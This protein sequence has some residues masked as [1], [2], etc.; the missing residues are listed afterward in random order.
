MSEQ[1][2]LNK[3]IFIE[4][5]KWVEIQAQHIC[6]VNLK[7][8]NGFSGI[9]LRQFK[10]T[11]QGKLANHNATAQQQ[12]NEKP[13]HKKKLRKTNQIEPFRSAESQ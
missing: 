9:C 3:L 5:S 13:K 1:F 10:F 8:N 6:N 4:F 11:P 2:I 7:G 12:L